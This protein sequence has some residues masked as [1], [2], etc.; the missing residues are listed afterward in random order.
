MTRESI[1]GSYLLRVTKRGCNQ[2][3][4]L[5]DL[6]TGKMLQFET[7][8]SVWVFLEQVIESQGAINPLREEPLD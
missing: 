3:F 4:Y 2:Q 6:K 5:H 1:I 7:W 8:V